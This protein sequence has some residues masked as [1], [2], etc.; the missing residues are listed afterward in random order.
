MSPSA[1]RA[2]IEIYMTGYIL[3]M[4]KSPSAKRAWI[5]IIIY[6]KIDK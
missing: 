6:S 3:L 4:T 1:K 5:E 2:W